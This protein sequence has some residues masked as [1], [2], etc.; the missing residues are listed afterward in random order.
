MSSRSR[1]SS[2]RRRGPAVLGGALLLWTASGCSSNAAEA[3]GGTIA[4]TAATTSGEFSHPFDTVPNS[5]GTIIYFTAMGGQ[6]VGAYSVPAMGGKAVPLFI[7]RPLVSP[8]GLAISSDDKTLYIADTAGG[9]DPNDPLG[10]DDVGMIYAL[11]VTGGAPQPIMGT[12]GLRPRS[13][14]VSSSD[15]SDVL[16]FTGNTSTGT[17]AVFNISAGGGTATP[18]VTGDPLVDPSG[19]AVSKSGD[20]YVVN[21]TAADSGVGAVYK[22]T[23]GVA[24][25][26]VGGLQV[27]YPAGAALS[28]GETLL[29]VSGRDGNL[30][31][32]ALYTVKLDGSM[33]VGT[34]NTGVESNTDPSGLHRARR[35]N[36]L[37]WA[38]LTAGGAGA[39]YRVQLN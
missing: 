37:S 5:D 26:Y 9:Y 11:P 1:G 19:I 6:G 18:V 31:T 3:L 16:W 29:V 24:T 25:L 34:A 2:W 32:S 36:I 28:Q 15:G 21:T 22:I 7:G 39:V 38:D 14:D 4:A 30:G 20:A 23:G 13:L 35:T 33:T 12:A 17:P 8:F 10:S 27:G